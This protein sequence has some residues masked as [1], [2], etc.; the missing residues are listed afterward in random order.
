M[1]ENDSIADAALSLSPGSQAL[2]SQS[3][4]QSPFAALPATA[5]DSLLVV[6][7]RPPEEVARRLTAVG[8]DLDAVGHVPIS[9]SETTYTGPMRTTDPV[10][11][12]DLTGL[13]MRLS[14][15]FD[16]LGPRNGWLLVENLN[17]FLMYASEPRVFRF[18][19]HV[20]ERASDRGI[21][22]VYTLA[23]DAVSAA[24][25]ERLLMSVDAEL[26]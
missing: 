10:V 4:L 18:V 23:T 19:D 3:S 7:S 22:G 24:V 8:A 11:P 12:D 25:Y 20:A 6:S 16:A 1:S 9:G 21:T 14:R 15:A 5:Y 13:S 26:P 17:V 2:L